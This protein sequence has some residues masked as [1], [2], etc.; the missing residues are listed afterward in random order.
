MIA[1][2]IETAVSDHVMRKLEDAFGKAVALMV[3]A[4]ATRSAGVPTCELT[5]GEFHRLVDAI[6]SDE[7]VLS[8]WGAVATAKVREEW[9]ALV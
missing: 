1:V 9:A 8:M 6:C 7:R 5:I 2:D 4:S 3:F